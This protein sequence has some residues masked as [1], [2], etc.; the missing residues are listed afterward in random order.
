MSSREAK[1]VP[2]G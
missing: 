2:T 1:A